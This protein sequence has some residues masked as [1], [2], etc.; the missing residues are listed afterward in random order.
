MP[1]GYGTS[2]IARFSWFSLT[3]SHC[4]FRL[5]KLCLSLTFIYPFSFHAVLPL[6]HLFQ[7]VKIFAYG[8]VPAGYGT[9]ETDQG[10]LDHSTQP[11]NQSSRTYLRADSTVS[12]DARARALSERTRRNGYFNNWWNVLDALCVIFGWVEIWVWGVHNICMARCIRVIR[13]VKVIQ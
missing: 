8:L 7:Q 2:E 10:L 13:L 3:L 5:C 4:H 1:A 11:S 12:E 9:S 6:F